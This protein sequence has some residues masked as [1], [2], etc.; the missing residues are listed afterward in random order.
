MF[1]IRQIWGI[2]I[3]RHSLEAEVLA[4]RRTYVVMSQVDL[5]GQ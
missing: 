2:E 5:A 4:V 3:D 1:R